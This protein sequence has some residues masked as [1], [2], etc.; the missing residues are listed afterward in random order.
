MNEFGD[1]DARS[2]LLVLFFRVVG[3]GG[4]IGKGGNIGAD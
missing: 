2:K 4:V 1:D 3:V